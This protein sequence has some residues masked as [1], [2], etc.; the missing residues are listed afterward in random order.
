MDPARNRGRLTFASFLTLIAAGM[1]FAVR[2]GLLRTWG[3]TF[4]FTQTELGTITGGGIVGFGI[5]LLVASQFADRVGYKAMLSVGFVLHL[6]SLVGT[7]AATHVYET[8][9]KAATFQ[10]L[11]WGMF[12]FAL[13]NGFCETAI[14]PLVA[15]LYPERKTHYLNILHAGWPG[16]L[17]VGGL[18]G[19]A[20]IGSVRWEVPV[21][22]CAVPTLGYGVIVLAQS[23]PKSEA[24]RAGVSYREMLKELASPVLLFLLLLQACV[25]YVELGTDSW[26]AN[27]TDSLLSG[28]GLYLFVYASGIMFVLRFFAGPIVERISPVGLLCGS[29]LLGASGLFL[30]GSSRSAAMIWLA[31]TIY[32]LGKTFLWPTMLGVVGERFP[33]G[34]AVTMGAVSAVAALSAGF[35][36]GPGIGYQQDKAASQALRLEAPETY[37]RYAAAEDSQFLRLG[38]VRG[39]DAQKVG[40]LLDSASTLNRDFLIAERRKDVPK[41]LAELKQWWA[42]VG[43]PHQAA[44]RAP[45]LRARTGGG[46]HALRQTAV[47]PLLMFLGYLLL[48]LHFRSR[49]GYRVVA[50]AAAPS[51]DL[52]SSRA[53]VQSAAS[54]ARVA[55]E[56]G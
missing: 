49:G 3:E 39:L 26:I 32:G 29:T 55:T 15:N 28:Q 10:C 25:G 13:G 9:G 24:A 12:M 27:I 16:G 11:Y 19:K 53:T 17:I 54:A 52:D 42:V 51:Q 44:D 50:L 14:N 34:G 40:V 4:G 2:A 22:L 6:L 20:L 21:A 18:V 43:S 7:L 8:A 45:L 56:Q 41:A 38:P 30:L 5:M 1:G 47:V 48:V 35:L 46:Q 33:R 23:F 37:H 31:V 36:G